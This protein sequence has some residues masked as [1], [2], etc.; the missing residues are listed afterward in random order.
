MNK[1]GFDNEKYLEEQSEA[2]IKR[3]AQFGNKLYLEFGGKLSNDLHAARVL[4]GFDSNGKLKLLQ[5]LKDR[6]EIIICIFSGDIER[7]K[8]RQDFGLAYDVQILRDIDDLRQYGLRIR[9]VVIT[10][11]QDR[12]IV[13][14]F[15]KKLQ[16]RDIDVFIHHTIEGYPT[17]IEHI[18]SDKGYGKND[19]IQTD[20]P[21]VVITGPGGG[22]G[23]LATCLS[24]IYHEHKHGVS[25]GYAKFETFPIWN[26]PLNH[27][28]NTAYEAATA[29]LG[30]INQVDP[31]HLEEYQVTAI[32]YNRDIEIFPVV[33]RFLEKIMGPQQVYKSATDMGVNR[34]GFSI[35]D[36]DVCQN[37][38]KQEIIR[39]FFKYNRE[40]VQGR[41]ELSTINRID[42]IM[43]VKMNLTPEH[44]IPVSYARKA[45]KNA[46]KSKKGNNGVYV[47]AAICLHDGKV[48]TGK[49]SPLMHSSSS[50]I[51]NTIKHLA[52]LPDEIDLISRSVIDSIRAFK[53]NILNADKLSLNLEEM[54]I[55]LSISATTNPSA[56]VAMEHLKD[57][58]GTEVH[59]THIPS[60]GDEVGW[61]KLGVNL[62]T[63]PNF[64]GSQLF[65]N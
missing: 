16:R 47:G 44:R 21:I 54:L 5:R 27:P 12:P 9:G 3:A 62:T 29:D 23:K 18:V 50:L 65:I 46:E 40:Y 56:Q 39:R 57:I 8:V 48:I 2:I 4:P 33:K 55:A 53:T 60:L 64:A 31:F 38:A 41:T 63:D 19:F 52:K 30:D 7:R 17:D 42:H 14:Q 43:R 13:N 1:I 10:R 24:Q 20:A 49:N 26:L 59:M 6:S 25:A 15:M 37:A 32:N 36:D 35:I 51:L 22:S 45:A 58:R 11:Y 61:R 28:V 34:A